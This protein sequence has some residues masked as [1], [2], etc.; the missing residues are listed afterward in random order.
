[1][2]L[3]LLEE[4]PQERELLFFFFIRGLTLGI[5]DGPAILHNA[6]F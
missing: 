3:I 1:M 5:D 6:A 4:D 2:P